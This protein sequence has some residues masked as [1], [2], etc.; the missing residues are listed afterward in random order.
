MAVFSLSDG[1]SAQ[2][3]VAFLRVLNCCPTCTR[4][5]RIT[6]ATRTIRCCCRC[7]RAA[8]NRIHGEQ[9]DVTLKCDFTYCILIFVYYYFYIYKDW[10]CFSR[11]FLRFVSDWVYSGVFR[12]VYGEFMIQVNEDYLSSRG[13]KKMNTSHPRS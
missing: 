10:L 8:V 5:R 6:A 1:M 4:K 9:N 7:L 13:E 3:H 11:T 2:C 12:D